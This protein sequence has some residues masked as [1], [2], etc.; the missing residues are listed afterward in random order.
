V[1]TASN[2]RRLQHFLVT[3]DCITYKEADQHIAAMSAKERAIFAQRVKGKLPWPK[4]S[5]YAEVQS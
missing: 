4:D 3:R 2:H 1:T 5:R